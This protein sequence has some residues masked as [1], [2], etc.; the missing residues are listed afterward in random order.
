M[1]F[2]RMVNSTIGRGRKRKSR[3]ALPQLSGPQWSKVRGF[4]QAKESFTFLDRL[5]EP[6]GSTVDARGG[7]R[8][9]G[10]VMVAASAA[11]AEIE[12]DGSGES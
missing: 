11:A 7:A 1:S 12:C 2:V 6:V 10:A 4:L 3:W 5:H 8:R 9:L